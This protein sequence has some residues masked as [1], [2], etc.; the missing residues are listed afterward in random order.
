MML[1]CIEHCSPNCNSPKRVP[2]ARCQKKIFKFTFDIQIFLRNQKN[3]LKIKPKSYIA[4][5]IYLFFD[6]SLC[7]LAQK[8][9]NLTEKWP[10]A[11]DSLLPVLN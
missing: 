4:M 11:A 7:V 6:S 1:K 10:K 8:K 5:L 3:F 2:W 9:K